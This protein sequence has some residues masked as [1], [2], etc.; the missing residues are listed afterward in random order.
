MSREKY[1]EK[2]EFDEIH[3]WRCTTE[4]PEEQLNWRGV[5]DCCEEDIQ[6]DMR[7]TEAMEERL[8]ED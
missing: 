4:L 2:N 6:E 3:C 8:W 7:E 1:I 5:C